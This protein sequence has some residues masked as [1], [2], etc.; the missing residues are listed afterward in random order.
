MRTAMLI[1]L[2]LVGSHVLAAPPANA[3]AM[4]PTSAYTS[5]D[6]D[7]C[8]RLDRGDEPGSARLRCKGF[9]GISLFVQ[10]G[11]DR[12]D[13]DAGREDQDELWSAGFD[14]PGRTIEWRLSRGRPFALIYRLNASAQNGPRSSRLMVETIGG[15]SPGCRIASIDVRAARANEQARR[16]ADRVLNGTARCLK[17]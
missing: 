9:A 10:N 4:R 16:A 11:D 7:R 17:R 12:H 5:L 6:L 14:E 1:A 8:A 13:I 3:Q 15:S 2:A